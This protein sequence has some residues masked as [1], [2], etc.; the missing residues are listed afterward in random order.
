MRVRELNLHHI[1]KH[2]HSKLNGIYNHLKNHLIFLKISCDFLTLNLDNTYL[3]IR[4]RFNHLILIQDV[5]SRNI[6]SK[7]STIKL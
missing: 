4:F 6:C 1:I 3:I 5:F 2:E 7:N